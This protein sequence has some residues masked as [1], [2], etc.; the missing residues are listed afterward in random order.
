MT[1]SLSDS[2]LVT[3]YLDGDR[4]ALAAIYDRYASGL[5]DTAAAM[6]SDRHDAAD[7][8]QDVFCIAAERLS[9]LREPD[10]LKPWLY[11]V[12]RNE[13]YRRTKKRRRAT[14]TDFQS[15]TVPDVVAP[16]DPEA[17][18]ASVA[19]AEL[20][21][22]VRSAAAGLDE[23]D[24]LILEL[25]IRQ[26]LS[27]ADL[28][29][30]L[31]VTAEQSYS[32]V[33]RM[34]ERV[35]KSLGA[36]VVAK[37]GRKECA[38]LDEILRD[39]DGQFSVLIRK[40]VARH[41]ESCPTCENTKGKVAPLALF[42]AAPVFAAPLGLRERVLEATAKVAVSGASGA[43]A[44]GRIRWRK[45]DGFPGAARIARHAAWWGSASVALVVTVGSI[46]IVASDDDSPKVADGAVPVTSVPSPDTGAPTTIAGATTTSIPPASTVPATTSTE[47]RVT[48]TVASVVSP[49][50][51]TTVAPM[52]APP[53]STPSAASTTS[54]TPKTST[55]SPASTTSTTTTAPRLVALATSLSG[56]DFGVAATTVTFTISN[57]NASKIDWKVS[58]AQP[59]FFTFAP[60]SGS[61]AAKASTSVTVTF[62]R[63]TA[64]SYS[65]TA[66]FPEGRF[67]FAAA[68]RSSAPTTSLT[69]TGAVGRAPQIGAI[70]VRFNG[71]RCANLTVQVPVSDESPIKSVVATL[72]L[73]GSSTS[74]T[75]T[76]NLTDSGKGAWV[77]ASNDLPNATTSVG[78]S[79]AATD[80]NGAKATATTK[81][82]RP[83]TC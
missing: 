15:E 61:I 35:D 45:S 18:G 40:R 20:A 60:A 24:Q 57:P 78:V 64:A 21:S 81:I 14:P 16:H 3:S 8:V 22:L 29:D 23:R 72:V 25:S 26:G 50:A 76:V 34:R 17:E 27:G 28:A 49:V 83:A 69:I 65:N 52:T 43:G 46:A 13:V 48:T 67:S 12:L 9:Q 62:A 54:M 32:L 70:T 6:L 63:A 56:I 19:Y 74:T 33:H 36:F 10:R 37:S 31:G 79:I 5:Y 71:T 47:P 82:A 30:A 59:T 73:N 4:G 41:V 55:T 42:G 80:R 1:T 11:A 75:R 68:I 2:Q 77:A 7:M 58:S 38:T 51:V 53:T 39:W 44:S 66:T